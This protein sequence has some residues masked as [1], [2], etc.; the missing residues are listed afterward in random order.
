MMYSE[1][2]A[3][4]REEKNQKSDIQKENNL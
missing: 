3:L 1:Y 4:E 2:P